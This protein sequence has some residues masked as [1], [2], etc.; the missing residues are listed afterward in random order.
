MREL[1]GD[2]DYRVFS[3][4]G[5]SGIMNQVGDLFSWD[6]IYSSICNMLERGNGLDS[7]F[8][9]YGIYHDFKNKECK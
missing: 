5:V 3:G 9:D 4:C 2:K 1:I 8:A 6:A 7:G